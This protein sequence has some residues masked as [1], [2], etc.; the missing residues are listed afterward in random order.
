MA[1]AQSGLFKGVERQSGGDYLISAEILSQD[2]TD[3]DPYHQ[4]II[5]KVRYRLVD[6]ESGKLIWSDELSSFHALGVEDVFGGVTRV[7]ELQER[8]MVLNLAE[9]MDSVSL[10][11][12]AR[13]QM[14][15]TSPGPA[16][17]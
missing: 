10:A 11:L 13:R 5:L 16:P 14:P 8:A 7:R 4:Y 17:E 12:G 15:Q 2:V 3:V 1:L 6:A 9:M